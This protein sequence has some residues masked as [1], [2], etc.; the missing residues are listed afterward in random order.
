MLNYTND[1][2]SNFS[3]KR[4]KERTVED[5]LYRVREWRRIYETGLQKDSNK[6]S[7]ITLQEAANLVKIPKK[8]LEDYIQIFNKVS[9]ICPIQDFQNKKMGFLRTFIRKNKTK[10][11]KAAQAKRQSQQESLNV[12]IE[13]SLPQYLK[14]QFENSMTYDIKEGN[15]K[16]DL[17]FDIKIEKLEEE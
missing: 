2:F 11:K 15:Q 14:N 5:A 9:L 12:K 17:N 6:E 10:I 4:V 7:R 8:T 1:Y 3:E 16:N 13:E